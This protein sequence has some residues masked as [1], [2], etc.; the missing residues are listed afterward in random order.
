VV[1][2]AQPFLATRDSRT[3]AFLVDVVALMDAPMPEPLALFRGSEEDFGRLVLAVARN[4][5]GPGGQGCPVSGGLSKVCSVCAQLLDQKALDRLEWGL[6]L[7]ESGR[8]S[9]RLKAGEVDPDMARVVDEL[10]REA[11]K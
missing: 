6:W 3:A 11:G 8:V 1:A 5:A 9:D 10:G 4:C 2:G 7:V